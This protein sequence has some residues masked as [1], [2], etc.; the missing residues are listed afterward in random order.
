MVK[1]IVASG[2][3]R[4]GSFIQQTTIINKLSPEIIHALLFLPGEYQDN[5]E[6]KLRLNG[7][8]KS[9]IINALTA[10]MRYVVRLRGVKNGIRI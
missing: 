5:F 3:L 4:Y 8:Y 6:I 9:N 1:N 7:Q 10:E 2:N